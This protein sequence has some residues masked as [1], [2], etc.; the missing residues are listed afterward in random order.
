MPIKDKADIIEIASQK[1]RILELLGESS[2]GVS[3]LV[4]HLVSGEKYV[5]HTV[6]KPSFADTKPILI[7]K[8]DLLG[9]LFKLD[10]EMVAKYGA[11]S[12]KAG[13]EMY[14]SAV[15]AQVYLHKEILSSNISS[16]IPKISYFHHDDSAWYFVLKFI[17]GRNLYD[18]IQQSDLQEEQIFSLMKQLISALCSL[19]K[20]GLGLLLYSNLTPS[21][22]IVDADGRLY[23]VDLLKIRF[24]YDPSD[25]NDWQLLVVESSPGPFNPLEGYVDVRS[26]IYAFGI[27][28]YYCLSGH[29]IQN[30]EERL[31]SDK[32]LPLGNVKNNSSIKIE[33][34]L[35]FCTE[36][37]PERRF[38]TFA[39]LS[40]AID[41][42]SFGTVTPFLSGY[43]SQEFFL[44][45][46]P[47]GYD[48]KISFEFKKPLS[49]SAVPFIIELFNFE[50][51]MKPDREEPVLSVTPGRGLKNSVF[52]S[53]RLVC[54]ES[55][56]VGRYEAK[57]RLFTTWGKCEF[58]ISFE[59]FKLPFYLHPPM[60]MM[61]A[62]LLVLFLSFFKTGDDLVAH[63]WGKG[64]W[65]WI[66]SNTIVES[67]N[68]IFLTTASFWENFPA[69]TDVNTSIK[70]GVMSV[71]AEN[72][73]KY[74]KGGVI[75]SL[76]SPSSSI[77]ELSI[78]IN[79]V[80]AEYK[81]SKA[82]VELFSSNA[83]AVS[84]SIESLDR[85]VIRAC[86]TGKSVEQI[87]ELKD[88][89]NKDSA[90]F[91]L[92]ISYSIA[93]YKMSCYI[94]GKEAATFTEQEMVDYAVVV[95]GASLEDGIDFGFEFSNLTIR[96]G[97][98]IKKI[99]PYV[100]ASSG[101]YS[102]LRK[103]DNSSKR[104][105]TAV[106]GELLEVR[107]LRENWMRVRQFKAEPREGWIRNK[108]LRMPKPYE[109]IP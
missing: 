85:A 38:Q 103:A 66:K 27:L 51:T 19:H 22:I 84:F 6:F 37:P 90:I 73:K 69:K 4:K 70:D 109:T 9:E 87:I 36:L 83:S 67:S 101:K 20:S 30:A 92:K 46:V 31:K 12:S 14:K 24:A 50:W 81:G 3:Y 55:L 33:K 71:T 41:S 44:G 80:P 100:M 7:S 58:K 10:R 95:Y 88:F 74:A 64:W 39:D 107:E 49:F 105:F 53:A 99:P 48:K 40:L 17:E 89:V 62:V 93:D 82:V 56:A 104:V 42:E 61:Y 91:N 86:D 108:F 13:Y 52:A 1:L 34:I 8:K 2:I 25:D 97:S 45:S 54:P 79:G 72:A 102:V 94:N 18:Y 47:K 21:N 65:K 23:I 77:I 26:E 16:C 96:T 32:L 43:S 59:L 60:G 68:E 57:C 75:S 78:D 28:F 15:E 63:Q 76:Y 106:K 11:Y 98:A 29:F 5:L 35:G